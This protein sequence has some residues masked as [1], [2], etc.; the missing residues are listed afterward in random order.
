MNHEMSV[1][2]ELQFR[3]GRVEVDKTREQCIAV[4][5]QQRWSGA[6]L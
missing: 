6:D 4:L 2:N 5:H 1:I 3:A